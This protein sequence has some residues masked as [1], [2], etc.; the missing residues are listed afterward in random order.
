[1]IFLYVNVISR[2]EILAYETEFRARYYVLVMPSF[3]MFLQNPRK[4]FN[5]IERDCS[6]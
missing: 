4:E 3:Y 5:A 2:V 6:A 1:M